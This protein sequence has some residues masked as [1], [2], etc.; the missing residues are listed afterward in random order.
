MMFLLV[1]RATRFAK[2]IVTAQARRAIESQAAKDANAHHDGVGIGSHFLVEGARKAKAKLRKEGAHTA[3]TAVDH[4]VTGSFFDP[5]PDADGNFRREHYCHR[6]AG[7]KL[8]TRWHELYECPDNEGIDAQFQ[9]HMAWITRGAAR[10]WNCERCRWARGLTPGHIVPQ[11]TLPQYVEVRV[12]ETEGFQ[13]LHAASDTCF[14]DG[15][16]Y[17]HGTPD[18]LKKVAAGIA[19]VRIRATATQGQPDDKGSTGDRTQ[20]LASG[21]PALLEGPV[22]VAEATGT[23][24]P[25]VGGGGVLHTGR[26]G[27]TVVSPHRHQGVQSQRRQ[28]AQPNAMWK[29]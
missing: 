2:A 8:A 11:V 29:D 1:C 20:C 25:S 21:E 28:Q 7:R 17:E 19:T 3:A 15:A 10:G 12:W 5:T 24:H 6:C 27:L 13:E 4:I 14:T 16:G 9:Q 22:A 18:G 23:G 26:H